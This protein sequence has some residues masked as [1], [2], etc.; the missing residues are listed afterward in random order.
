MVVHILA[1]IITPRRFYF[2]FY[3]YNYLSINIK[4]NKPN[5]IKKPANKQYIELLGN[6]KLSSV[7]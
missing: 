7:S 6:V 2:I 5:N 3:K 1:L 4:D